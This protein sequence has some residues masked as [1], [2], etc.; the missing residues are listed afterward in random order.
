MDWWN[1]LWLN[2][3][4]ANYMEF[5][6]VDR[7]FPDWNIVRRLDSYC[8]MNSAVAYFQMTRFYAENIAYS[9]EVDGLRSSRAVSTLTPNNTNIMGLFD[10]ISY[11]KVPTLKQLSAQLGPNPWL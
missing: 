3:G 4:F 1:D 6:C 5:K 10:A 8:G 9:Q 2:E 11:H 7:L